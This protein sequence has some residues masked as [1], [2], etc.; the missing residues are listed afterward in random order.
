ML[1]LED[2]FAQQVVHHTVLSIASWVV[3]TILLLG[4]HRLGWRGRTVSLDL[5]R[6]LP[7]G[8]RLLRK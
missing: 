5:K 2:L 8:A 1:F 4:R 6:L 7:T 3:F